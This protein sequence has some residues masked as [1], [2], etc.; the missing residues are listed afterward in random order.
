MNRADFFTSLR[1]RESGVFG[2]SLTQGQVD[3]TEALLDAA[4]GLP[5][6]HVANILA[7][8]YHETGGRMVP[9]RETFATSDAQ[10][11]ARLDRE[12]AKPGHGALRHVR[13]PYWRP[14]ADGNAWFGRGHIQL[15]HKDNYLKFGI[16]NP[17]DAMRMDVSARVA[18]EGMRDGKFRA[19]NKLADY[20]FPGDLDNPPSTNPRRIVNGND[21]TDAKV[22]GYHR[23]FAAALEAAGYREAPQRPI[24]RPVQPREV[25]PAPRPV[26]VQDAV[27]APA[28]RAPAGVLARLL[29][30]FKGDA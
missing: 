2:T 6:H 25:Y 20:D 17:E 3:G 18:V 28:P 19:R 1:R 26:P 14:D 13:A 15:T 10:A 8:C 7:Q 23:A 22:A 5:L 9:V 21:G 4:N 29:S 12:W 11:I 24:A 30:L 16:A 27:P